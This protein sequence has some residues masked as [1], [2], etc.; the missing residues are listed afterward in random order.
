MGVKGRTKKR[1][2]PS[3]PED[4]DKKKASLSSWGLLP[5]L[6]FVMKVCVKRTQRCVSQKAKSRDQMR[7]YRKPATGER[8]SE[9]NSEKNQETRGLS[10]PDNEKGKPLRGRKQRQFR[11][12]KKKRKA[13]E[14]AR[15]RWDAIHSGARGRGRSNG[16]KE[17]WG[18]IQNLHPK[19]KSSVAN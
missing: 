3:P 16:E 9:I 7:L 13:I 1:F 5:T 12:R 4:H 18:R 10:Y 6:T 19:K 17:N 8:G 15:K 14:R 2:I 11:T